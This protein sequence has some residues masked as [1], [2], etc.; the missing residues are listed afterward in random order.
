MR[1]QQL[2]LVSG[3]VRLRAAKDRRGSIIVLSAIL[4]V[5]IFAFTSFA[6]DIGFISLTKA[7]LQNTADSAAMS[8]AD[9]LMASIGA[10]ATVSTEVASDR[11][12]QAAV[13]MASFHRAGNTETTQLDPLTDVRFGYRQWDSASQQWI[14][15]WGSPPYNMV[16]V[17]P[18]RAKVNGT[19]LPLMFAR[20]MGRQFTDVS[21]SS[22][23]GPLPGVGFSLSNPN[24]T[25]DLLPFA[26]DLETWEYMLEVRNGTTVNGSGGHPFLRDEYAFNENN[27]QVQ[28]RFD[29]IREI[30]IYPHTNNS[31]PAGNRGTV[32]LGNPN[33]STSDLKRQIE[34]GLNSDDFSYFPNNTIRMDNGPLQVNGDTGVSAGMK[35]SLEAIIGEIRCVPIFSNVYGNGN[36][37]QYEVVKFV[38]VRIMGAKL[39]GS[40][41]HRGLW[42]QP[43]PYVSPDVVGG[44]VEFSMDS[45]LTPP[46]LLR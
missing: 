27:E 34:N 2:K 28:Q 30:N 45:I 29:G 26:V 46:K 36:N 20:V 5:V 11:A 39:S 19:E 33:N 16:E 14:E 18:K 23:A 43:A 1:K 8:A 10:G 22:V 4:L 9:E 24:Q 35:S 3:N 17:I 42:V 7:Q 15:S 37:A 32:D 21:A 12:R 44:N 25:A 40:P 41:A 31:L 6:V 38:S 13:E